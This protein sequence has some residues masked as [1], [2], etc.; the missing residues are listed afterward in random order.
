MGGGPHPDLNQHGAPDLHKVIDIL[1]WL[2]QT[3]GPS[4]AHPDQLLTRIH[5]HSLTFHVIGTMAS[6]W[7]NQ[8]AAVA[9]SARVAGQQACDT[10][11][12]QPEY[13]KMPFPQTFKVPVG[14]SYVG[15]TFSAT[16]PVLQFNLRDMQ[17]YFSPVL[18]CLEP[19][20]T[21]GLGDAISSTALLYSQFLGNSW[22]LIL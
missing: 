18:V 20:K 2:L 1:T 13:F 8:Q 7:G 12:M 16:K 10:Q 21:V 15:H 3:Y 4:T 17:F 9:A 14:D 5:F 22:L 11:N 19:S 6:R